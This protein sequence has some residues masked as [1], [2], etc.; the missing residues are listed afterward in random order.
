MATRRTILVTG[1]SSGIGAHCARRLREDGWQVFPTARSDVDLERLRSEGFE[2]LAL[3]YRDPASIEACFDAVMK[4]TGGRLDALFN[5]GG[6]AQP[7]AVEDVPMEALREQFECNVFGYHALTLRA[8]P[9]MRAQGH[10]RIV[11]NSSILG[12]LTMPM[13]GA[14]NAS[15]H[16]LNGLMVSLRMELEGS[17]VFVSMIE[18]GSIPSRIGDNALA[19][20]HKYIDIENSVHRAAYDRRMAELRSSGGDDDGRGAEPV[21]AVLK[22][23]LNA[24]RPA[25]HY[26]VTWQAH[27]A[28]AALR[29]L[30]RDLAYRLLT[31]RAS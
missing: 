22:K 5:N 21:Y 11:H 25:P 1:C 8:V 29:V 3:D 24:A 26:P 2:A 28:L 17:G 6:Y 30:P 7:G 15:K 27:G 13:R 31:Y 23:A 9:V 10:G 12:R 20:A 19:Y 4:A 18:P 16:A 14:Y